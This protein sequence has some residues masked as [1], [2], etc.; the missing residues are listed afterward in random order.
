MGHDTGGHV[1]DAGDRADPCGQEVQVSAPSRVPED[2]RNRE[3]DQRGCTDRTS[4]TPIETRMCEQDGDAADDECERGDRV[5]PVREANHE[6]VARHQCPCARVIIQSPRAAAT[7]TP[8]AP[9]LEDNRLIWPKD[10][11]GGTLSANDWPCCPKPLRQLL[12]RCI[13]GR[14]ARGLFDVRD[15]F[16]LP[17]GT[18]QR[19]G[20]VAMSRRVLRLRINHAL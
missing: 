8:D 3:V 17:A 14:E 2:E 20:K 13:S 1:D 12:S 7:K 16:V 15:R 9:R 5:D 19:D 6:A 10:S 4:L 18:V 11:V